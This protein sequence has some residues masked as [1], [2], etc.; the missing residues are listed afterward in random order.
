ML[1]I[2]FLKEIPTLVGVKQSFGQISTEVLLLDITAEDLQNKQEVITV[3][4]SIQTVL[5]KGHFENII[6][7]RN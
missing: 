1:H 7:F 4:N 6:F 2:I 3:L 5:H